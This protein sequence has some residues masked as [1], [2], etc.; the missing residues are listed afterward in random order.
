MQDPN[1]HSVKKNADLA[2]QNMRITIFRVNTFCKQ[3]TNNTPKNDDIDEY[4]IVIYQLVPEFVVE[5]FRNVF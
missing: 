2:I 3:K 4:C 5:C 1:T